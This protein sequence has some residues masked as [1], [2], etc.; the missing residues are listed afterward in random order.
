MFDVFLLLSQ[1]S[2]ATIAHEFAGGY[3]EQPMRYSLRDHREDDPEASSTQIKR[4]LTAEFDGLVGILRC[5]QRLEQSMLVED[6]RIV[7]ADVLEMNESEAASEAQPPKPDPPNFGLVYAGGKYWR[8]DRQKK[9]PLMLEWPSNAP[10]PQ[11]VV[12]ETTSS[13]SF[14]E[15]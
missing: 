10:K 12:E 7:V 6:H 2:A 3:G 8:V 9:D 14:Q 5:K 1:G 15:S 11:P 13:R 4:C